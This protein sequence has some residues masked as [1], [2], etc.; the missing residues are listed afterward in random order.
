MPNFEPT[1]RQAIKGSLG[2]I[3]R[4]PSTILSRQ[5]NLMYVLNFFGEVNAQAARKAIGEGLSGEELAA[6]QE[7]LVQ[8]PTEAMANAAHDTALHNTFQAE[9]GKFGRKM[10]SAVRSEPTGL[11]KFL[12]P[13]IKTPINLAKEAAYYSPYGILKGTLKGDVDMQARGMVGSA[14]ALGIA[15]LALDGHVTGGGP[16]DLKKRSTLEATGWQPY[17]VK[18]G[19][20]Y[21]SYRRLEPVGLTMALVSDA[22]HGVKAGD[23]EQVTNSKV[24]TAIRHIIRN[25]QDVAFVPTLSNLAEMIS[26]PGARARNFIARQ[27]ASFIPA[28][29]KDI[30]QTV[31]PTVRKPSGSWPQNIRQTAESRIP[32]LTSK[33]PAVID[34]A[35]KPVQRPA[36]AVGGAN[37]FP[38][39]TA[40]HDPVLDELARLGVSAIQPPATFKR[41]GR[42]VQL[43]DAQRQRLSEQEGQQLY[44][45]LS[46]II[47]GKGWKGLNDDQRLK[48]I[49]RFRRTIEGQRPARITQM[50]N[51][52]SK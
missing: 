40:K 38:I 36:S 12:I 46:P 2:T 17:S 9:L 43:T 37:P 51:Q 45:I 42:T 8:H 18:I 21:Y 26:N 7:Y 35:G 25:L 22:V 11:L 14:I 52:S 20:R 48:Q 6:R 33:V 29:V 16:V 24:D 34:V 32:G 49:A 1:S 39:T 50:M 31:D 3:V 5:T 47:T 4:I 13:F 10:Q 23:S 15:G 27:V 30:A 19:D 28:G 44:R 41:R